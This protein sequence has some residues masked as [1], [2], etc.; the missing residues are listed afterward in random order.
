MRLPK[1]MP[2]PKNEVDSHSSLVQVEQQQDLRAA[3]ALRVPQLFVFRA[4]VEP[5]Q[6]AKLLRLGRPPGLLPA[7]VAQQRR[8]RR[9][10]EPVA[11]G[12]GLPAQLQPR[13]PGQL[14]GQRLVGQRPRLRVALRAPWDESRSAVSKVHASW[15]VHFLSKNRG[16]GHRKPVMSSLGSCIERHGGNR[17]G[18][19]GTFVVGDIFVGNDARATQGF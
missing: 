9:R 17:S 5:D 4:A 12:R 6:P 7:R 13:R 2:G 14:G 8:D 11:A 19:I 16:Y 18:E 10:P 3:P 1:W 15:C